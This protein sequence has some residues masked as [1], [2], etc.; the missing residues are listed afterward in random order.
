MSK[1][2]LSV[3]LHYQIVIALILGVFFGYLLPDSTCCA[4]II[5]K[6][7]GEILKV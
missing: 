3:P 2:K 7:E 1:S 5:A 4:V 6:S